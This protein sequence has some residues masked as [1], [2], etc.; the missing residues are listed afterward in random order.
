MK[1]LRS[2]NSHGMEN[3]YR[4]IQSSVWGWESCSDLPEK[5]KEGEKCVHS[6]LAFL[7]QEETLRSTPL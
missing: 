5:K 1:L 6:V 7:L 2:T 3:L 4:V